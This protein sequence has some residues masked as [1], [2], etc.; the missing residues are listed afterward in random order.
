MESGTEDIRQ[1]LNFETARIPW[2]ELQRH[3]ARGHVVKVAQGVDLLE[4]AEALGLDE[5]TKVSRWMSHGVIAVAT[6]DD[7]REW[8]RDQ[9]SPWA[10][11]VAPWV[12]VQNP[13]E[14]G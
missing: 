2:A 13:V 9:A 1:K 3:F 10:V 11:V 5:V 6:L 7:A 8:N 4:V 14:V 12:L